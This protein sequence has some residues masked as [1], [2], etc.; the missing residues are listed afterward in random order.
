[1]AQQLCLQVASTCNVHMKVALLTHHLHSTTHMLSARCG[2]L[3]TLKLQRMLSPCSG[4][5]M[6][7]MIVL[8]LSHYNMQLDDRSRSYSATYA[9][10]TAK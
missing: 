4:T 3:A 8:L 1:M 2:M 5:H 10:K 9:C 7:S 6:Y